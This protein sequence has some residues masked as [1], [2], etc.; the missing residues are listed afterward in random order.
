MSDLRDQYKD[1]LDRGLTI[2]MAAEIL[3][4]SR[5]TIMRMIKSGD[6]RAY[7]Q[8]RRT[9]IYETSINQYRHRTDS[10]SKTIDTQ[11]MEPTRV[12][13]RHRMAMERI[14]QLLE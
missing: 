10:C 12:S 8:G 9:R 4:Y 13:H 3:G 14:Q 6:L 1:A 2:K 11:N 5:D 7:G